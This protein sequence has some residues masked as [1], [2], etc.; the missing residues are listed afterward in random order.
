MQSKW[1]KDK[2]KRPKFATNEYIW[3][4][5]SMTKHNMQLLQEIS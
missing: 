5:L 3:Y 4:I 1:R 2:K